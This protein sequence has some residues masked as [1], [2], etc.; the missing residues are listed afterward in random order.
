MPV[1]ARQPWED[2]NRVRF[3]GRY[4]W[5]V[6]FALERPWWRFREVW[7]GLEILTLMELS[8][9]ILPSNQGACLLYIGWH[10]QWSLLLGAVVCPVAVAL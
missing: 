10:R 7:A 8:L 2:A 4:L 5:L 1:R 9:R 6:C 3:F